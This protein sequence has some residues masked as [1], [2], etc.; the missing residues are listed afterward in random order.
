MYG[1]LANANICVEDMSISHK[2]IKMAIFAVFA[3][4]DYKREKRGRATDSVI[5]L[6]VSPVSVVIVISSLDFFL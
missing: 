6:R 1:T 3:L 5:P 2:S 4:C